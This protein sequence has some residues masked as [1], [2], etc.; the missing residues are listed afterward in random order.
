[1]CQS[2]TV[3]H[4]CG[5]INLKTIVQ[6]ADQI[7]K[8]LKCGQADSAHTVCE[9]S[10]VT[11]KSHVFPDICEK[12]RQTGIIAEILN[13]TEKKV[14]VLREWYEM[15]KTQGREVPEIV[16]TTEDSDESEM[17]KDLETLESIEIESADAHH[18]S[19][20]SNNSR[21]E[22][23]DSASPKSRTFSM[24]SLGTAPN[25]EQIKTR[26]VALRS[27]TERLLTKIRASKHPELG[28]KAKEEK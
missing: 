17:F 12:C 27:R 23:S 4:L 8:L 21:P 13:S 26:V 15:H 24:T 2:H 16:I 28:C 11:D 10:N 5:H 9:D 19:S 1:M 7:D 3:Y 20:E 18:S 25:L 14:E 6:C 22:E